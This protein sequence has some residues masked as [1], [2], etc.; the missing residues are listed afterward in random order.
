M[1]WLV[2]NAGGFDA[3]IVHGIWQFQSFATWLA[4]RKIGFP[5]FVFVHGALDPWFKKTYPLKHLKK[6]LYWP[7]S[8]YRVL[9]DARGVLFTSEEEARLAKTSFWLYQAKEYV[10]NYGTSMPPGDPVLQKNLFLENYPRIRDKRI[11]LFLSRIHPKKGCDLLI[12]AFENALRMYPDLHLVIAGPDDVGW[13]PELEKL[14]EGLG[15]SEA[16]T[17]TGMLTGDLK[18]GAYRNSEVFILPSHSENFGI[19]VAESLACRVPVLITDKV[20]IWR[21]I[22]DD[23]AGFVE[24]DTLEGVNLLLRN[25]LSLSPIEREQMKVKAQNCF[26]DR[27][28]IKKA[29]QSLMDTIGGLL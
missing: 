18:W 5:Y 22:K 9:R 13:K 12:R 20:N 11:V 27:F 25:W 28:E 2:A 23:G 10:I 17:W 21:E 6:W 3:V 19:V 16:I 15:I 7:W 14:A 26:L 4:Y 29:A 24:P 8:E 1:S